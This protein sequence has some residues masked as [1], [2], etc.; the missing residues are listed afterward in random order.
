MFLLQAAHPRFSGENLE[1]NKK[2]YRQFSHLASKHN[3]TPS[4]L[5]LAWLLHQGNDIIPIPG[6]C[7]PTL[8]ELHFSYGY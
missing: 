2:L 5:A 1:K 6:T 4:Q 8:T 7:H 3:C